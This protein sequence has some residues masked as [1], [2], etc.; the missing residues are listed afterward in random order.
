MLTTPGTYR[1]RAVEAT[2]GQTK[3]GKPQVAVKLEITQPEELQGETIYWFGYFSEKSQDR[4]LEA[5]L[6]MGTEDLRNFS[7]LGSCAVEIVV[8]LEEFNNK[9]AP[10]VRWVNRIGKSGNVAIKPLEPARAARIAAEL[11]GRLMSIK[12]RIAAEQTETPKPA[13]DNSEVPF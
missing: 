7:G 12:Q 4:T 11:Q 9:V 1:A 10:K 8:V 5:L 6:T 2:M 3:D 13:K